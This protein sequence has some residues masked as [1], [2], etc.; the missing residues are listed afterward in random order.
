VTEGKVVGRI[1]EAT[2]ES[3]RCEL[4]GSV[5]IGD[6]L[7]YEDKKGGEKFLLRV[8]SMDSTSVGGIRGWC[9]FMM[10]TVRPP[11]QM[12]PL[13]MAVDYEEDGILLLGHDYRGLEIRVNVNPLFLHF[14]IAGMTQKGKTHLMIV[15][16]EELAKI[17]IPA[18]V[19]DPQGEFANFPAR[20]RNTVV[21]E[22]LKIEDLLAHLREKRIVIYNLLG[23]TKQFK[24]RRVAEILEAL[25]LEKERDYRQAENNPMLLTVPPL[26]VFIDEAE[27]FA[28]TSQF[29]TRRAPAESAERIIDIAKRGSK[30]GT[31]LILA[32][33]RVNMLDLDVRSN[34][35]SAAIFQINNKS[36]RDAVKLM[37]FVTRS[38]LDQVRNL[39]RGECLIRGTVTMGSRIIQVRDIEVE[40]SKVVDFE[41]MLGVKGRAVRPIYAQNITTTPEGNIVDKGADRILKTKKELILE[42][43]KAAFEKN[44]GDGVLIREEPLTVEE[45]KVLTEE[46][47]KLPFKTHLSDEDRELIGK[48]RKKGII[49]Q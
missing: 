22:E 30:M 36:D 41:G 12:S 1:V 8:D 11:A 44:R 20:F 17:G 40:R 34:C 27:I 7:Y 9:V 31:G 37:S 3:A 35:N 4:D 13:Y 29:I 39:M 24:V 10:R 2:L 15:M 47:I 25:V 38:T 32:A 26:L 19:I 14:L 23:L 48:L 6:V 42:E 16:L 45:L 46:K 33:Q 18:L 49:T 43:D 21:V 5:T 28:P